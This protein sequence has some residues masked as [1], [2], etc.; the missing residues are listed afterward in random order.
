EDKARAIAASEK[1]HCRISFTEE[2]PATINHDEG[3][4]ILEQAALDGGLMMRHLPEAFR[5]SEDFGHYLRHCDGA[6][7]GLGAG[8][9]T[10]QLHNPEY[11]F[12]DQIISAGIKMFYAIYEHILKS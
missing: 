7:F 3:V 12:P 10:P 8:E 11:D 4:D 2:F 5:W 9:D 6:Y 1:L